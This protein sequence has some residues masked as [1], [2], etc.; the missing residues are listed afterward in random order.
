MYN[1]YFL[2]FVLKYK[3]LYNTKVTLEINSFYFA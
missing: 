3:K 1:V 2:L